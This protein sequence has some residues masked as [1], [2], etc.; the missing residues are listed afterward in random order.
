MKHFSVKEWQQLLQNVQKK[1]NQGKTIDE[2]ASAVLLLMK[3]KE[4]PLKVPKLN[5]KLI[6]GIF[7]S[8]HFNIGN[9]LSKYYVIIIMI[10]LAVLFHNM[11]CQTV[12]KI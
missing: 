2:L 10:N 11:P 3:M 12:R 5:Q 1:K 9:A 7:S 8:F 6:I 4:Y